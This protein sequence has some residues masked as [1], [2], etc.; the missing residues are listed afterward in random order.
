MK[1]SG[2]FIYKVIIRFMGV[3]LIKKRRP[4]RSERRSLNLFKLLSLN[5][6]LKTF[7]LRTEENFHR[8]NMQKPESV[9]IDHLE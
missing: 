2:K 5:K 3:F 7:A 1:K 8:E 6:R 4:V 9:L